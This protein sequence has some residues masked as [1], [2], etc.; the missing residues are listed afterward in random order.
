[1][2]TLAQLECT[3]PELGT[4]TPFSIFITAQFED[5]ETELRRDVGPGKECELWFSNTLCFVTLGGRKGT[6][7]RLTRG[8]SLELSAHLFLLLTPI[9]FLFPSGQIFPS[10]LPLAATCSPPGKWR[11]Q[12]PP[13]KTGRD[14]LSPLSLRLPNC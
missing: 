8:G 5:G 3:L 2:P 14:A 6:N 13:G 12:D 4:V 1:M 11:S 10:L 9:K 7:P